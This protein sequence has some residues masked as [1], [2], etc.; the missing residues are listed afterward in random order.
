MLWILLVKTS[1]Y[2]EQYSRHSIQEDIVHRLLFR[3]NR[4]FWILFS[5]LDSL[6]RFLW[7]LPKNYCRYIWF[8]ESRKDKSKL[9]FLFSRFPLSSSSQ[10]TDFKI[11]RR[12]KYS[13]WLQRYK[14]IPWHPLRI[15]KKWDLKKR[16][17]WVNPLLLRALMKVVDLNEFLKYIQKRCTFSAENSRNAAI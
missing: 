14:Q 4:R 17:L 13:T 11:E 1:N 5:L 3:Q 7:N 9:I 8:L 15:V 16:N 2:Y 10:N 12:Y 6:K